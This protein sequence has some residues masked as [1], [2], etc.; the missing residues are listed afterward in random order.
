MTVNTIEITTGEIMT[1]TETENGIEI[2]IGGTVIVT[3]IACLR[4]VIPLDLTEEIHETIVTP[5]V[6]LHQGIFMV[7]LLMVVEAH[8]LETII[9]IL[10]IETVID[11]NL[12]TG[13][14]TES[15]L[16]GKVSILEVVSVNPEIGNVIANAMTRDRHRRAGQQS[17]ITKTV[18]TIENET[19]PPSGIVIDLKGT[20]TDT[21]LHLAHREEYIVIGNVL[22]HGT[23]KGNEETPIGIDGR[24]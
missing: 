1:V 6:F 13:I 21:C 19:L 17:M 8:L 3:V 4:I 14:K 10:G 18:K 9:M 12:V 20:E 24:I 23:V 15:P 11:S 16:N 2:M 22:V 7:R 5:V